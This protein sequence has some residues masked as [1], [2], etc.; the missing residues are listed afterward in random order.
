MHEFNWTPIVPNMFEPKFFF[1]NQIVAY[2]S[3]LNIA[4]CNQSS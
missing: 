1:Q 3:F 2:K 4:K